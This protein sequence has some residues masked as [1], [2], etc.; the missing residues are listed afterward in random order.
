VRRLPSRAFE[1]ERCT[2]PVFHHAG[3]VL[4]IPFDKVAVQMGFAD[5]VVRTERG[6]LHEAERRSAVLTCQNPPP[7]TYFV[8]TAWEGVPTTRFR[9]LG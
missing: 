5:R 2:F 7:R 6:A 8:G 1:R 3:V 4:E 9:P